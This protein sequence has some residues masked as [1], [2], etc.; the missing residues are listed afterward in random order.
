MGESNCSRVYDVSKSMNI[1]IIFY[2][3]ISMDLN[4]LD[5]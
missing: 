3:N 4:V 2:V 5:L 1:K